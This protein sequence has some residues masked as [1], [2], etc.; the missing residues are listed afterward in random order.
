MHN[1]TT[2]LT[3]SSLTSAHLEANFATLSSNGKKYNDHSKFETGI[4][5]ILGGYTDVRV[6]EKT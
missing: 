5:A 1:I 6:E 4:L 2:Y 3:R